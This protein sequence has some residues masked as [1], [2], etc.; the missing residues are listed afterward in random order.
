M[1]NL[2][3][4]RLATTIE[5]AE[6]D[7]LNE[8]TVKQLTGG[9]LIT[10]NAKYEKQITFKPTHTLFMVTNHLPG[11]K[12][13]GFAVW[14]RILPIPF[15]VRIA[16]DKKDPRLLEKLQTERAGILAWIVRGH[17]EWLKSGLQPP[18]EVL[19]ATKE[20]M[21]DQDALGPFLQSACEIDTSA[22]T[23]ASLM[24]KEYKAYCGLNGIDKTLNRDSF[25]KRMAEKFKRV[26]TNG[27][28]YWVGIKLKP[29]GSEI[30]NVF[31]AHVPPRL[32]SWDEL[33]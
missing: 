1:S 4:V 8:T 32:K 27:L 16:D 19:V 5:T 20:Y 3:G 15:T 12:T 29:A 33:I 11:V 25:P 31:A 21:V 28:V 9:D 7:W 18:P 17:H 22:R 30:G 14:R 10:T 2:K 13:Q 24:F 6:D 23:Q 26:E